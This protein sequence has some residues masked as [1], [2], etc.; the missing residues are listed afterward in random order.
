M[1]ARRP[2]PLT[3]KN[4][5]FLFFLVNPGANA[6][7][8]LQVWPKHPVLRDYTQPDTEVLAVWIEEFISIRSSFLHKND[9]HR[10]GK[11]GYERRA[12]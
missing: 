3:T 6:H 9:Y 12:G 7:S 8:I 1:S 5:T 4:V 11:E 2:Y 10:S